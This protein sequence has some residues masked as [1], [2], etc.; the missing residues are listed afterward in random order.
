A[1]QTREW[2]R[3]FER[4]DLLLTPTTQMTAF[5]LGTA[6]PAEIDGRPIGEVLQPNGSARRPESGYSLCLPVNLAGLPAA[7][8]PCGFDDGGLPIGLQ[9]VGPRFA[10]DVVLSAAAAWEE[11]RPWNDKAP[12]VAV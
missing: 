4:F 10:D 6:G 11:I 7:S 3:F 2:L 5:P 1:E 8:V 9:I 12:E